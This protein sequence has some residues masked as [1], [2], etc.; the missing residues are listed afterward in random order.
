MGSRENRG[1]EPTG[2]GIGKGPELNA[3]TDILEMAL[4]I[5]RG[6][7]PTAALQSL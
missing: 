6:Q 2:L 1:R 7:F 3:K 5:T 4:N